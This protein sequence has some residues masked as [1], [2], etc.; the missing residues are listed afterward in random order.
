LET[1]NVEQY[2]S[3]KTMYLMS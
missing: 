3:K 2:I 1:V